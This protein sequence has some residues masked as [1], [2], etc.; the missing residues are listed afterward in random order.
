MSI[1][2][3]ITLVIPAYNRGDLVGETI[4]SA[5]A[6]TL[7][8]EE[9]I[10]VDDGST[11]N[12]PSVI[13]GYGPRVRYIRIP[14]QGVQAAR[15]EGVNAANTELV[16]LSDS[17]D[18]LKP[19]FAKITAGWMNAHP[20]IDILFCNFRTFDE[21]GPHPEDKF[22]LGPPDFFA[23]ARQQNEFRTDIPELYRRSLHYQPFFPTGTVFRKAF[24][25]RIGGYDRTFRGVGAEDWEFTLRAIA[26]GRPAA[27]TVPL[28]RI[29]KHARN[30]SRDS[31]RQV[32]G[33]AAILKHGLKA[34]PGTTSIREEI[35]DAIERRHRLAFD[36]T[37]ARGDFALAKTLAAQLRHTP[38]QIK[39]WV[40]RAVISLPRPFAD[41]LWRLTQS[42]NFLWL[43]SPDEVPMVTIIEPTWDHNAHLPGNLGF[44]RILL[45][46][47]PG[48]EVG[49]VGGAAQIALMKQIAPTELPTMVR[50]I[51]WNPR[52][53][54]DNLPFDVIGALWRVLSLPS[55]QTFEAER[56]VLSSCSA[57][58][59]S[60]ITLLGLASRTAAYLHGDANEIFEWRS[61]NLFRRSLQLGPALQRFVRHGGHLIVL[62]DRIR[63]QLG[64]KF[65]WLEPAL[66]SMP[67]PILPEEAA[68]REQQ[69]PLSF[70]L[71]IGFAGLAT[72]AKGFPDFLRLARELGQTRPGA[73]RFNAFG[74]LAP[75]CKD[76]D[77]SALATH[78]DRGL[79]RADF[80]TGLRRQHYLFVWHNDNYYGNAASGVVYDAINLGLPLIARNGTQIS[81]WRDQGLD[82]GMVFDDMS[83]VAATLAAMD[84]GAQAERYQRQRDDLARLRESLDMRLLA[85]RFA[86]DFPLKEADLPETASGQPAR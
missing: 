37:F 25:S 67:H 82:I 59:I 34:H 71:G 20:E 4:D 16:A 28:A 73:F 69:K 83:E 53:D 10:V 14:N 11:D 7:P 23:G 15:N 47:Y 68:S 27:Y 26:L 40:K 74:K 58:T 64:E 60:A 62:E 32:L 42:R 8:F 76:L 61:R 38:R 77:Q 41:P 55:R 66:H 2:L 51:N 12:T 86:Q 56:I 29:R 57:N 45:K 52:P 48:A 65:A 43:K 24:F 50:F 22:A 75:E 6:Q 21:T 31:L 81:D 85:R 84:V 30:I 33:E 63:R 78:A 72:K 3:A 54:R 49:F 1:P 9:I 35:L 13:A 79:S 80:I 39:Y 17:D 70:P 18:I 5:L 19:A 44:L 46:A 36:A